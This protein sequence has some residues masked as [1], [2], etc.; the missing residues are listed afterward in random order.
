[1]ATDKFTAGRRDDVGN[2]ANA[3]PPPSSHIMRGSGAAGA[4][5]VVA[6]VNVPISVAVAV[7][8]GSTP[9]TNS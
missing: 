8:A 6:A 7:S 4:V 1:M 5:A 3:R 2:K 9:F